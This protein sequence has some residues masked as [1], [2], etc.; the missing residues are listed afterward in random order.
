VIA[1]T[2][3]RARPGRRSALAL[4]RLTPR[5]RR[6][7]RTHRGRLRLTLR[8]ALREPSGALTRRSVRARM[9]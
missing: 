8:A 3:K 7:L 9:R 4:V 2:R 1:R 5:G 6:V